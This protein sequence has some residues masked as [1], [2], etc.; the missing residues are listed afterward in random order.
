MPG[1]LCGL[2]QQTRH[3]TIP[4]SSIYFPIACWLTVG[5]KCLRYALPAASLHFKTQCSCLLIFFDSEILELL[6]NCAVYL[7]DYSP[8][9]TCGRGASASPF[10]A[11]CHSPLQPPERHSALCGSCYPISLV[12]S[13]STFYIPFDAS[14]GPVPCLGL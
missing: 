1:I 14:D 6:F 9:Y 11:T 3:P 8:R 4:L 7:P 5:S 10:F 2:S 13:L 12:S